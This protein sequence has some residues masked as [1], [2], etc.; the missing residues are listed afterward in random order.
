MQKA[1]MSFF[2]MLFQEHYPS[3]IAM[4]RDQLSFVEIDLK[5]IDCKDK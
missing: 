5:G 4:F 1:D 2:T 3:E